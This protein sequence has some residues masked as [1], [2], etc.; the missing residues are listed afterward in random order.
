M[1]FV[2]L[3]KSIVAL[4]LLLFAGLMFP[5]AAAA[6]QNG[7]QDDFARMYDDHGPVMLLIEPESGR[8]VYANNA[9][10][11]FYG[12]AKEQLTAMTIQQINT[13]TAE[14]TVEETQK[15]VSEQRNYFLFTH[16]L[17]DGELRKVEV[18]SYP[19][20]YAGK[21]V[22]FSI[23][24]DI[25]DRAIMEERQKGMVT[26]V[27]IAA[28]CIF[29]LLL[30]LM[31]MLLESNKSLK[32]AKKRAE[33]S[34][35]L[36]KTFLNEDKNYVFLKDENLKFMFVNKALAKSYNAP[37]EEIIGR[38]DFA[39]LEPEFAELSTRSDMDALEKGT[40]V[41][42]TLAWQGRSFRTTKFPVLLPGGEYGVGAYISDIT[43][44]E[45]RLHAQERTLKRN[46][47]LLEMLTRN[48]PNE[49]N[50]LDYAL[51]E[52]LKYSQSQIGIIWQYSETTKILKI[53]S[54]SQGAMDMCRPEYGIEAA[55]W[56]VHLSS[57]GI[58]GEAV[59]QRKPMI[60]NDYR[61]VD[62]RKKGYPEGHVALRNFMC[63]PISVE[64]KIVALVGVGNKI[65]DYTE[66]DAYE[67]TLIMSSVWNA[68]QRR[69]VTDNL[70][71][72]RNKYFQTLLSIGD[73]V[74]VVDR[75]RK[76]E[77]INAIAAD[78]MNWTPQEAIGKH[79]REVFALSHEQEGFTIT[80]PIE[81]VFA[82]GE[83]QELGNHAI[84]TAR[85]GRRYHLED[86]AAPIKDDNGEM[87][88][89]VLVFRDVTDKKEQRRKIEYMSFH[90]SLTG[91]YN[92]RFFEEEVH[93]LD[94]ERNL[95]ISI[96]MADVNSL[97]LTN[98]IFGHAF[99]D[100]LL[101]KV[102]DVMKGVCRADDIIARWGGDEFVLL[103]PRT[104]FEEAAKIVERIKSEVARQ[105]IRA[106]KGS[107]SIGFDTKTDAAKDIR[108]VLSNAEAKMY[109]VKTLE[110][111]EVKSREQDAIISALFE[112]SEREKLHASRVSRLCERLGRAL[113]LPEF[114]IHRLSEA[115]RLH[116]IGKIVLDPGILKKGYNL[117]SSEWNVVNQHPV[118]G[119]R[120]LNSFDGTLELAEA[121]L[122]HHESWDGSGY[123]KGLD[124]ERIPLLARIIAVA[125][126]YDR[127]VYVPDVAEAKTPG[128]ALGEIQ[129]LA[130]VRFDPAVVDALTKLLEAEQT[131]K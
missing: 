21:P 8:I 110:R 78:L 27:G 92:R 99:G 32:A 9:A 31:E 19:T 38:D 55:A 131:R 5:R 96:L 126:S 90:D 104:G 59:R 29:L 26:G 84:L 10:A 115:G 106:I 42:N 89:V 39:F 7:A 45:K 125:E 121:V 37:Y 70:A 73:A 30:V 28:A 108:Q 93:R 75:D 114:D 53:H 67:M 109:S 52:M 18:Y 123:P 6:G 12:Y 43:E 100:M 102:A 101:E 120:I 74:M 88:G 107:V 111:G 130:G 128:E 95:P 81:K 116:D 11:A 64:N 54:W 65:A 79:Y 82:T 103:L 33:N 122:A 72:E 4:A 47:L 68:V 2:K 24:Y 124:G 41:T 61:A 44:E 118:V 56:G 36:L 15:A 60:I 85:G 50:Q 20:E 83:V 87:E 129:G 1:G 69:E 86:S 40:L 77:I 71:Y 117:N 97:K 23:I 119:Y 94:T 22:L 35:Q 57:A 113:G 58:W 63:V 3:K 25:M 80:D 91:L 127:M 62:P 76:V 48:F 13:L 34:E 14:E 49:R 51:D 16:R 98:D 46:S 112:N 105:Q 17:A 66:D